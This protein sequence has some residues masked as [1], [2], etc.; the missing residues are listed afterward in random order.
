MR[1]PP[2]PSTTEIQVPAIEVMCR[3]S[4]TSLFISSKSKSKPSYLYFSPLL[5]CQD[6]VISIFHPVTEDQENNI[7]DIKNTIEIL[8]TLNAQVIW[9]MPNSDSGSET[10]RNLVLKKRNSNITIFRNIGREYF[11]GLMKISSFVVGNSSAGLLEAPSFKI[12]AINIGRRQN[13]RVRAKNVFDLKTTSKNKLKNLI[14]RVL[15]V[16]KK[17]LLAKI[18]NPY[19]DGNSSIRI[20]KI[21]EKQINSNYILKKSLDLK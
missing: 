20:I 2:K 17:N 18:K 7:N 4:C 9:I 1:K 16:K 13:H 12:P 6:I 19:G 21:L 8:N 15:L 10:I 11:L 3:P 14:D 5:I